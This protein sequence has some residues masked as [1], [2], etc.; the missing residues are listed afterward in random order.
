LATSFTENS[1]IKCRYRVPVPVPVW[2]LKYERAWEEG[3]LLGTGTGT[4]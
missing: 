2:T 3:F 1:F 4:W